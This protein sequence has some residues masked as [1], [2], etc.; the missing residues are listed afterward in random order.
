VEENSGIAMRDAWQRLYDRVKHMVER[1]S[2]IDDPKSRFH[3]STLEHI[4]ELCKLLPRLNI[5]DDPNLEAMRY[6][7]E[8]KLAGLSKDAV[9]NDP[10]LRQS[11]IDEASDIMA[12][13]GAF[14]G[15]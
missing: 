2:K 5:M 13:M 1:L 15:V 11:K 12:R 8:A 6:E 10:V 7:V 3:E 14:M 4:T 9:V